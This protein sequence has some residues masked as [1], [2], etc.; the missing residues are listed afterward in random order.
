[1]S[2]N[3][4]SSSRTRHIDI[5]ARWITEQVED[6]FVKIIYVKTKENLLDG[7]TKNVTTDVYDAHTP[8]YMGPKGEDAEDP[9]EDP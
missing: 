9:K 1:M 7:Y 3:T 8:Q 6:G 4:N 5:K 2:E